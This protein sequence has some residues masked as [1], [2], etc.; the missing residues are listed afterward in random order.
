MPKSKDI[1][2]CET[3]TAS[4]NGE[5][6][7]FSITI[8]T[9]DEFDTNDADQLLNKQRLD[10]TLRVTP[11]DGEDEK[12]RKLVDDAHAQVRIEIDVTGFRRSGTNII[13][14][15]KIP[16]GKLNGYHSDDFGARVGMLTVHKHGPIPEKVKVT[17]KPA[18]GQATFDE[19]PDV[20]PRPT[21]APPAAQTDERDTAAFGGDAVAP[22]AKKRGKREPEMT[23]LETDAYTRGSEA[24]LLG[25]TVTCP[26]DLKGDLREVWQRG[27]DET[28]AQ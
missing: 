10:A 17:S 20:G 15:A 7:S 24:G 18:N 6:A 25:R 12:Q 2:P 1:F 4:W 13:F 5:E 23:A 14:P 9:T 26:K 11:R 28:R 27:Y 19:H 8:N 3:G 21:N 16:K 22:S